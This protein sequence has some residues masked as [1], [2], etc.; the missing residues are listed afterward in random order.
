[1]NMCVRVC[2]CVCVCVNRIR[3]LLPSVKDL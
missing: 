3:P 1:V 2:V